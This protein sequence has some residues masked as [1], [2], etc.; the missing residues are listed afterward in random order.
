[1]SSDA[2]CHRASIGGSGRQ[3]LQRDALARTFQYG[4]QLKDAVLRVLRLSQETGIRA[5][6]CHAINEDAKRFYLRH[7]FVASPVEPF[8]VRLNRAKVPRST[9]P[10]MP[11]AGDLPMPESVHPHR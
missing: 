11:P 1:M 2:W 3:H 8:T 5:L 10:P 9:D 4:I 6:L 7:G